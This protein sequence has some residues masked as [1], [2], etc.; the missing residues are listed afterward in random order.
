[1]Q[2]ISKA[3]LAIF[4]AGIGLLG[5][6]SAHATFHEWKI[7]QVYSNASGSVQYIEFQQPSFIVD[8][9]RFLTEASLSDSALGHNYA[10]PTNLPSAPVANQHFLVATPGYAA[11][12]GV[13]AAD[14]VLPSND[15]FS[16]A[17]DTITYAGGIDSLTFAAGQLPTDGTNS[18]HRAWG[19][20]LLTS[21]P[22]SATNFAGQSGSVP[23]P[24][25]LGLMAAGACLGLRRRRSH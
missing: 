21:G 11:L 1:M 4:S 18:L 8:D 7:D 3:A 2:R 23:E 10:F 5:A 9:E 25:M 15:F 16:T 12:P 17:G 6:S 22:N 24:A 20:T 13:P 19:S 14:Y